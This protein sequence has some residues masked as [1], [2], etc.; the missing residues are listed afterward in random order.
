MNLYNDGQVEVTVGTDSVGYLP[1]T[2]ASRDP[3]N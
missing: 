1:A 3:P 2:P